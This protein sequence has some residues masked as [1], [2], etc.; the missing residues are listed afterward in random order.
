MD[1]YWHNDR[2]RGDR[3]RP[4]HATRKGSAASFGICRITSRSR[5]V[6]FAGIRAGFG[7]ISRPDRKL[8]KR[9]PLLARDALRPASLPHGASLP[10]SFRPL[11]MKPGPGLRNNRE[12]I[13]A[14]RAVCVAPVPLAQKHWRSLASA[15]RSWA[16]RECPCL[17]EHR[18]SRRQSAPRTPPE[19]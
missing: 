6:G 3:R 12:T 11:V 1:A 16:D 14:Y 17:L 13:T 2:D 9:T 4:K 19:P 8:P 10:R 18:F 15:L 5:C 7:P